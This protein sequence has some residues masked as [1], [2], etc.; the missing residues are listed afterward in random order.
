MNLSIR[1][2]V[3]R[4]DTLKDFAKD[5]NFVSLVGDREVVALQLGNCILD[6]IDRLAKLM[7]VTQL[8]FVLLIEKQ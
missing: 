8:G 7:D 5:N 1:I 3:A 6:S 2:S 4:A